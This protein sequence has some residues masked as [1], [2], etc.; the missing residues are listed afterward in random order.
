MADSAP[1]FSVVVPT[2]R[3]PEQLATCL[4][5]LARLEWPRDGFEVIVVDDG[6]DDPPEHVVDAF[7]GAL[8]VE[9][10]RHPHGGPG[11]ARNAG[12]ARARGAVL[13][14]TDDDCEPD[15]TWL[16]ALAARLAATPEC[17][18]GGR[19]LCGI[20]GN[21]FAAASQA[22]VTY[23]Y[24]YYADHPDRTRFFTTNNLALPTA[25][26]H[27]IGGFDTVTLQDT[28]EDR[29]LCD[30]WVHS[31]RPLA[32]APDALVRH[33]H[34]LTFRSFV[35]QHLSYGRGA[36]YFHA[37]RGR[38]GD[39]PFRVEPVRFYA[40]MI[41][42]A[43]ADRSARRPPLVAALVALSQAVYVGAYL[44]E[45]VT[46]GLRRRRASTP[47]AATFEAPGAPLG[48]REPSPL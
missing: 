2:Y 16:T 13:A 24:A 37:V 18:V 32:Y 7:R 47:A 39:R 45:L 44:W 28:A 35:R 25:V 33:S 23:L 11:A 12:A 41:R 15:P 43:L 4:S 9:L 38:R 30:R 27:A 34:N 48:Q 42:H 22:V 14:F 31:G 6:S 5:A 46:G 26:F 21:S 19:V 10:V 29:E 36:V 8:D 1:L 20:P 40:G 17:L 3:R